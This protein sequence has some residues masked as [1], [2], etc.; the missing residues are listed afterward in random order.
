V[1]SIARES[2]TLAIDNKLPVIN[3]TVAVVPEDIKAPGRR[4]E[5]YTDDDIGNNNN[6][7]TLFKST[8]SIRLKILSFLFKLFF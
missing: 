8:F 7:V 2:P 3:T 1:S 5:N 6:V 4:Q